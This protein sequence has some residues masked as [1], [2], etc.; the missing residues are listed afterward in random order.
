MKNSCATQAVSTEIL[1]AIWPNKET[2]KPLS[3][4]FLVQEGLG[5]KSVGESM[6]F[7]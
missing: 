7:R 2:I 3:R 6:R 1:A 5:R 4:E